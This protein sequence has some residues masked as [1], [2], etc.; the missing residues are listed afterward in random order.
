MF[1]R[2]NCH[3]LAMDYWENHIIL[4][5]GPILCNL[6]LYNIFSNITNSKINHV[7][8]FWEIWPLYEFAHE[9]ASLRVCMRADRK[10]WQCDLKSSFALKALSL[11]NT[12]F[13]SKSWQEQKRKIWNSPLGN[14][15]SFKRN[16][17]PMSLQSGIKSSVVVIQSVWGIFYTLLGL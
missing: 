11:D 6:I 8:L 15:K 3:L 16:L 14:N 5:K 17:G 12:D 10:C 2:R 4:S 1:A 13:Y 7:I 9:Q